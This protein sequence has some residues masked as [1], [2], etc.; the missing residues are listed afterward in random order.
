MNIMLKNREYHKLQDYF[1]DFYRSEYM[2]DMIDCGNNIV[3][4]ILNQK[5]AY[6]QSRD[7]TVHIQA[8]LPESI[9]ISD[10]QFCAVIS[11]LFDN[12]IE[13]AEKTEHPT[14]EMNI[15]LIKNYLSIVCKNT[16]SHDVLKDNPNL[17][18]TKSNK[19]DHGIGLQVV[20]NIVEEHDGMIQ[21]EME[22]NKFKAS[23]MLQIESQVNMRPA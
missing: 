7:I 1:M 13:A 6:A 11:N 12:A 15:K 18:T 5:A 19:S 8:A 9:G 22:D 20:H 3:N 10:V 16:V 4:A 21:F 2:V 17:H 14:I 23:V